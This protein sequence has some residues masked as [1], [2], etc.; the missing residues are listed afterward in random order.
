MNE[1]V[2]VNSIAIILTGNPR[3]RASAVSGRR[4]SASTTHIT[5]RCAGRMSAEMSAMV[6]PHI[7]YWERSLAG[8]ARSISSRRKNGPLL[9]RLR[10]WIVRCVLAESEH[11]EFFASAW[12]THP[13]KSTTAAQDHHEGP[14]FIMADHLRPN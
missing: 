3:G 14:P 1:V 8:A 10:T 11:A 9:F 7:A 4:S 12:I 2:G 5:R 13:Q 6:I